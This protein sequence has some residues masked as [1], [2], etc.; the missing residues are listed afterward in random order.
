M[1]EKES[2]YDCEIKLQSQEKSKSG[3]CHWVYQK[4]T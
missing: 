3:V 1:Q 4:Y 2:Q